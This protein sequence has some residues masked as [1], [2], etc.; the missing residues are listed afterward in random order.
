[1]SEDTQPVKQPGAWQEA[2]PDPPLGPAPDRYRS[3]LLQAPDP[4]PGWRYPAHAE[5]LCRQFDGHL[6]ALAAGWRLVAVTPLPHGWLLITWE[7][8]EKQS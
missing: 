2:R 6:N 8:K 4:G 7:Q 1:M 5:D 3:I